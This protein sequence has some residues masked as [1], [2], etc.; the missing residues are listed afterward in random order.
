MRGDSAR[1]GAGA[2]PSSASWP[3]ASTSA[4]LRAISKLEGLY[5]LIPPAPRKCLLSYRV[6]E[7]GPVKS[8][9]GERLLLSGVHWVAE[10]CLARV[11]ADA[12]QITVCLLKGLQ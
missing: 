1:I 8:R 3:A 5:A 2:P 4:A 12:T 10:A 11:A 9:Y 6:L 7:S